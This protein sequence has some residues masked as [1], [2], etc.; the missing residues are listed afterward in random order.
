MVE[1]FWENFFFFFFF[2][3]FCKPPSGRRP[4]T[5]PG[6]QCSFTERDLEWE[7][8]QKKILVPRTFWAP[9]VLLR[10]SHNAVSHFFDGAQRASHAPESMRNRRGYPAN[11][12]S[13][14]GDFYWGRKGGLNEQFLLEKNSSEKKISILFQFWG[15]I[16]EILTWKGGWWCFSWRMA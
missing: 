11:V 3:F 5:V 8:S 13:R 14:P 1:V 12:L 2:F 6:H 9:Y 15:S 7:K 4:F 16:C 10:S